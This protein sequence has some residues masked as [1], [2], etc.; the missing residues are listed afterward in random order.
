MRQSL[1]FDLDSYKDKSYGTHNFHPYPAKFVPQIPRQLIEI[2]TKVDDRV[3]DPF[4]GSGTTLVEALS[5]GRNC[6]GFDVNDLA[7]L[8]SRVKTT[9][10]SEEVLKKAEVIA[11]S[12]KQEFAKFV[13]TSTPPP[14]IFNIEKWFSS[15]MIYELT[16]IREFIDKCEES[17]ELK[18]FLKVAFAY[19]VGRA[20]NQ[21]SDT[22]YRAIEKFH[23]PG[24]AIDSF[25]TR[26]VVMANRMREFSPALQRA[27]CLIERRDITAN[28]G[29]ESGSIDAVVTSP[30]YL[31]SYDYY[32]YHKHR[33]AWLG[34]D[35]VPIQR[36]ELGSRNKH[37]DHG[38]GVDKYVEAINLQLLNVHPLLKD[39]AVYC[40]V[41]GDGILRGEFHAADQMFDPLF[42]AL[43]YKKIDHFRFEQRKYTRAFTPRQRTAHKETHILVY[44]KTTAK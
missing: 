4:C 9:P 8:I 35:H 24:V 14:Q 16:L 2:F 6:V 34:I 43:R 40:C 22:V 30:P 36:E 19:A 5:L 42:K 20:S 25:C 1:H 31:N 7:V 23:A 41:V 32:L 21:E 33:M 18:N 44:K 26:V 27:H 37:N 10:L 39:G 29:W 3:L 28:A 11:L 15:N 12:V 13:T 38:H 17:F